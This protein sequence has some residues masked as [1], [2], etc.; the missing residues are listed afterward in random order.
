MKSHTKLS[1][2]IIGEQL[3]TIPA[4]KRLA[5]EQIATSGMS[6]YRIELSATLVVCLLY[7]SPAIVVRAVRPSGPSILEAAEAL[8]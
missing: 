4:R 1:F 7:L 8:V 2:D 6:Q 5:I 3:N